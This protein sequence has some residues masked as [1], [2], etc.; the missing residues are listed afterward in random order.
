TKKKYFEI[1]SNVHTIDRL[2]S[3]QQRRAQAA[4]LYIY[5]F[6]R[7]RMFACPP[8]SLQEQND[9]NVDSWY[10]RKVEKLYNTYEETIKEGLRNHIS[11][12]AKPK[13]KR[14]SSLGSY[15]ELFKGEQTCP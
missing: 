8:L 14:L 1:L 7:V 4:Y 9:I 5:E 13:F 6:S 11:E 15:H 3:E 10:W 2:T 12:V